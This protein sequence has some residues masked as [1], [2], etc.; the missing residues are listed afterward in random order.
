[1]SGLDFCLDVDG[2]MTDGSF[3]YDEFGKRLKRFGPDDADALELLKDHMSIFFVSSDHRGFAISQSRIERDMGFELCL[4]PAR[5]RLDWLDARCGLGNLI[6]M[7][8]GF[9]DA[10]ILRA[11]RLG[12]APRNA[13]PLAQQAAD[14]VTSAAGG[15]RAVAEAAIYVAAWLHLEI[16]EFA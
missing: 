13:S 14:F 11:A 5:N 12:I 1:M 7:G 6:Y 2:V 16:P 9:R 3:W 10:P 15:Q 4:V 8:D